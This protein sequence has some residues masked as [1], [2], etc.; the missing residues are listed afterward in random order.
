MDRQ[1]E[2]VDRNYE[3]VR[4]FKE[5][6]RVPVIAKRFDITR[7][8]VYQLVNNAKKKEEKKNEGRL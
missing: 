5:G 2:K 1:L 6:Y 4:M 8:R 7:C 3:V